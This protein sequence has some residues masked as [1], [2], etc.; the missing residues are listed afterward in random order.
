MSLHLLP[1]FFRPYT[2]AID[3]ACSGDEPSLVCLLPL[4][5][6][7][8]GPAA[9][10]LCTTLLRLNIV[11]N[12]IADPRDGAH[13]ILRQPSEPQGYGVANAALSRRRSICWKKS[14]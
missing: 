4:H 14:R 11:H 1:T 3:G 13:Q 7:A 2:C 5:K 12:K 9:L 6:R 8:L 10:L